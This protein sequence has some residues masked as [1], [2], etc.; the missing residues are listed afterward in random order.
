LEQLHPD[1]GNKAKAIWCAADRSKA[2]Q[3][4]ALN[5]QLPKQTSRCD[6]PIDKVAVLAHRLSVNSTPTIFFADGK[7]ML[8]AYPADEIESALT[9]ATKK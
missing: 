9:A 7:R 4:W 2:W 8:G 6:T 5:G 1:A 3:D